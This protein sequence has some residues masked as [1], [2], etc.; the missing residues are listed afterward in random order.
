MIIRCAVILL[1]AAY[2][3]LLVILAKRVIGK[4]K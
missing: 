3:A 1:Y 2:L 4:R